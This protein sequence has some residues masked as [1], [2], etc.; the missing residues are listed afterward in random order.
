M[1]L[2]KSKSSILILSLLLALG[3]SLSLQSLL[4][5]WTPPTATPP[6]GNTSAPITAGTVGS[7]QIINGDFGVSGNF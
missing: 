4:A 6:D 1:S 3:L 5:A 2:L 7:N